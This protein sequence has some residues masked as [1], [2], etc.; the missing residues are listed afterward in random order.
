M[1]DKISEKAFAGRV[2]TVHKET[3]MKKIFRLLTVITVITLIFS[4]SACSAVSYFPGH[5][6][7][8]ANAGSTGEDKDK[9][10]DKADKPSKK[11]DRKKKKKNAGDDENKAENDGSELTEDIYRVDPSEVFPEM[12]DW[13]FVFSSGAGG[14]MTELFV[15]PDGTFSGRYFDDDM[16]DT[17]KGYSHGTHYECNFSGKFS[18]KIRAAG[19]LMYSLLIEDIKYEHEPGTQEIKDDVRIIYSGPY[20][21]EI[22]EKQKGYDAPLVFMKAGAV[23][24]ALTAEELNWVDPTHFGNYIGQDFTYIEDRPDN[25]PV[26]ILLNTVDDTAFR[27]ENI[28]NK[29]KTFL[30]NKEKL[31]GLKNSTSDLNPDGTYYFVDED[32]SGNFRVINACFKTDRIYDDYND[33]P[34]I[35]N[36]CLDRIYGKSA[37]DP[38]DVYVITPSRNSAPSFM[39]YPHL[40]VNGSYSQYASWYPDKSSR[41]TYAYGRFVYLGGYETDTSFLYAYIVEAGNNRREGH[42]PDSS[43]ADN[44]I[45][46]L[47]LTGLADDI[48]SAGKGKGAVSV[49]RCEMKS[50]E[51]ESVMAKEAVMV[52]MNDTELIKKYHLEDAAF[53]DDYEIVYPDDNFKEYRL[54]SGSDTPFYVRYPKD[55]FHQL[56]HAYDFDDYSGGSGQKDTWT[57]LMDL[58]LNADG[59]VVYGYEIY[60]P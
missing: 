54:A 55:N 21:L 44:Y 39:D 18:D 3:N 17:G 40:L 49:M 20:G 12:S 47:T 4:L 58:Y 41:N 42:L 13:E 38:N 19:P 25:L 45:S 34:S 36:D 53:D 27:G 22:M 11:K 15:N 14:W 33:G 60:T 1:Y 52:G 2:T 24:S 23:T 35:V 31:P 43:F 59:E 28:S 5:K 8:A 9:D 30:V 16:G 6:D 26:A 56:Y 10:S 32:P 7:D 50:P 48:S 37:P 51:R 57:G 29:N 46:S